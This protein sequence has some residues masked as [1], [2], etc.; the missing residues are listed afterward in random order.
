MGHDDARRRGRFR[1]GNAV[2]VGGGCRARGR[3]GG[4]PLHGSGPLPTP[5]LGFLQRL[6]P[7]ASP[8]NAEGS[9][10]EPQPGEDTLG[11]VG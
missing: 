10:S 4:P 9:V 11:V 6:T 1:F 3:G 5:R 2:G 8:D 7:G